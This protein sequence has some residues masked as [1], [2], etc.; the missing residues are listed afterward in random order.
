MKRT[1]LMASAVALMAGC[2][3]TAEAPKPLAPLTSGIDRSYIDAA[4]R[5]QD[6]LYRHLN[7]KWLD[8]FEIP[9]DKARFGSFTKLSDDA[10]ANLKA[11]IDSASTATGRQGGQRGAADR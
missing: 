4:V 10:E 8:S 11:I 2:G 5:P 3:K 7:G 1:I 6:D 9:A